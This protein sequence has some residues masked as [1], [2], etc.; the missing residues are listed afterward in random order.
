MFYTYLYRNPLTGVPFYVGMGE[1]SRPLAHFKPS[2][3]TRSSKP[4]YL[5]LNA[6]LDN[7]LKPQVDILYAGPSEEVALAIEEDAIS[8]YGRA[9][10]DGG[11]LLNKTSGG[12]GHRHSEDSKRAIS[13]KRKGWKPSEEARMNMRKAQQLRKQTFRL[14]ETALQKISAANKGKNVS[15][16]TRARISSRKMGVKLPTVVCPHCSKVGAAANMR[17]W[18]FDNCS[19]TEGSA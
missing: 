16:E 7:E 8:L 17:R 15:A 2:I 11:A 12:Q 5:M 14:S 1:R 3:R 10:V 6:L 13:E 18:H 4:F 19:A 9:A